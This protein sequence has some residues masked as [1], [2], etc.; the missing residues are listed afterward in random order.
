MKLLIVLCA[1]LLVAA[2]CA[3]PLE[4]LVLFLHYRFQGTANI[5]T[6][7][8][9]ALAEINFDNT[10]SSFWAPCGD[11]T[12]FKDNDYEGA[13]FTIAEGAQGGVPSGWNDKMSSCRL[14]N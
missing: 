13:N 8:T 14:S 12:C 9:P 10:V 4:H 6:A 3:C 7:D 2:Q 5:L 1:T 11:W